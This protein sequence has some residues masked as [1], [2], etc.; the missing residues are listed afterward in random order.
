MNKDYCTHNNYMCRIE[1]FCV[2]LSCVAQIVIVELP[3]D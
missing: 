1:C 3:N 2:A